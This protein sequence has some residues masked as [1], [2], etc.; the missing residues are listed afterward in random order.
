MN[1]KLIRALVPFS[2]ALL[3]ACGGEGG[4]LSDDLKKDLEASASTIELAGQPD[5]YQP[6]RFVSELEQGKTAEPVER[7]RTPRRVAAKTAGVEKDETTSP[8][9]ETAQDLQV[10]AVP[11]ESPQAPEPTPDAPSVPS[12]SPRPASLPVDV[13]A[14]RGRGDGN[15]GVGRGTDGTGIGIGDIIGVVIRGGGVGPDHCPPPR[16]RRPR[17][18]IG[19]RLP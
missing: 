9:P 16:G 5:T 11:S 15:A 3:I 4:A 6:M 19:I 13:P 1:I 14:E 12:V 17:G 2:A 8:A 7:T 18:P 10:A